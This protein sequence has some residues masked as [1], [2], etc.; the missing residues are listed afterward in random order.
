MPAPLSTSRATP[1]HAARTGMAFRYSPGHGFAVCP[2]PVPAFRLRPAGGDPVS[3]VDSLAAMPHL[4]EA[5][6]GQI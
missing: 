1:C 2:P 3:P 5:P 4:P 6:P